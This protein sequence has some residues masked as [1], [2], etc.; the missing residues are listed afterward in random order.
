MAGVEDEGGKGSGPE[1]EL[2]LFGPG[3]G[4]MTP[5]EG[6]LAGMRGDIQGMKQSLWDNANPLERM[7]HP[8]WNPCECPPRIG[9]SISFTIGG[10]IE[11][12]D[13]I[14]GTDATLEDYQQVNEDERVH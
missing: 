10:A 12:L 14:P 6:L 13:E 3:G 8:D 4:R 11:K 9:Y 5:L 2:M 7:M 1:G